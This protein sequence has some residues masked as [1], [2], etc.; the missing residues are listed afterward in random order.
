M[1]HLRG[2]P[3]GS[4]PSA[5]GSFSMTP[6]MLQTLIYCVVT[7]TVLYVTL[8]WYRLR[9]ERARRQL[10]EVKARWTYR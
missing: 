6:P 9:L 8:L 5:E 4:Q 7:F 2:S 10:E 3:F 1:N